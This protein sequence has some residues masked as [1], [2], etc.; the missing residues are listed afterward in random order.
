MARIINWIRSWFCD[1]EWELDS[2]V[3]SYEDGWQMP[4]HGHKNYIC[5]KCLMTKK[6]KLF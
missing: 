2:E 3:R 5:K 1:H 6:I 4:V